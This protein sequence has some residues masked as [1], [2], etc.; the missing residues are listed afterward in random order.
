MKISFKIHKP[1]C[2]RNKYNDLSNKAAKECGNTALWENFTSSVTDPLLSMKRSAPKITAWS[3]SVLEW[4]SLA[5]WSKMMVWLDSLGQHSLGIFL[6][7]GSFEVRKLSS[8]QFRHMKNAF[9]QNTREI[10][11]L[12]ATLWSVFVHVTTEAFPTGSK[13]DYICPLQSIW[14]R[15][16][17]TSLQTEK[18]HEQ[19]N[20]NQQF[21]K[22]HQI[23][24]QV[25]GTR[26]KLSLVR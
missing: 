19:W 10:R 1:K 17:W 20:I 12:V 21:K 15:N 18:C 16:S 24:R 11:L 8:H 22:W 2:Q 6:C 14:P 9:V 4:F 3:Y 23:F 25:N 7:I 26:K 13:G 5:T